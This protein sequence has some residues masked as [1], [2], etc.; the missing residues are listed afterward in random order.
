MEN[1]NGEFKA[2]VYKIL[3]IGIGLLLSIIV[4]M[5]ASEINTIDERFDTI[6]KTL[7]NLEDEI[8][9]V[10]EEQI[11]RASRMG[12]LEE[13]FKQKVHSHNPQQGSMY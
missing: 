4:S 9:Q 5:A 11:K 6:T 3:W 2:L 10:R 13:D 1:N 7:K 12:K 8:R